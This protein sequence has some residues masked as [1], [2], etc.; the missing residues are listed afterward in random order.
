[1]EVAAAQQWQQQNCKP[2]SHGTVRTRTG[3]GLGGLLLLCLGSA[4][5]KLSRA[6][7]NGKR[8]ATGAARTKTAK[9]YAAVR[10][11]HRI[12]TMI[13]LYT[14]RSVR[15]GAVSGAVGH[16]GSHFLFF[17]SSFCSTN[18]LALTLL[19]YTA[20]AAVLHICV[21]SLSEHRN[22]CAARMCVTA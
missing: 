1:M 8:G 6:A 3:R 18:A 20:N 2:N 5:T 4:A 19:R 9:Q 13:D 22:S 12:S 14:V 17:P 7:A 10:V 21:E 16:S 11:L 15:R